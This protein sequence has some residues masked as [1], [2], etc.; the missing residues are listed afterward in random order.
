M[1]EDRCEQRYALLCSLRAHSAVREEDQRVHQLPAELAD[2]VEGDALVA[3]VAK[4]V[5][6]V[7]RGANHTAPMGHAGE[8]HP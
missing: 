4:Q 6:P 3:G 8:P 1:E 7:N 2:E 5:V